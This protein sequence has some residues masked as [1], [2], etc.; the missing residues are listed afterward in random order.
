MRD[1]DRVAQH[2]TDLS[3]AKKQMVFIVKEPSTTPPSTTA[4][5]LHSNSFTQNTGAC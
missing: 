5:L 3:R 1:S 2:V 4:F